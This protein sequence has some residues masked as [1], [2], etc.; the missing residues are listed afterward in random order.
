[1]TSPTIFC[2]YSV[3]NHSS[4]Y[5]YLISEIFANFWTFYKN[6]LYSAYSFV[7]QSIFYLCNLCISFSLL[8][9]V[10]WCKYTTIY[11]FFPFLVDG[12]LDSFQLLVTTNRSIIDIIVPIFLWAHL[13]FPVWDTPRIGIDYA[14]A[15]FFFF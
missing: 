10:S 5:C 1:M 6:K 12:H 4:R 2:P 11:L 8:N 13:S 3:I 14:Y 9:S 15:Q 7:F